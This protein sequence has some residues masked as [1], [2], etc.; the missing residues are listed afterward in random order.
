M[1]FRARSLFT[2]VFTNVACEKAPC[3][4]QQTDVHTNLLPSLRNL[5][6]FV[7]EQTAFRRLQS[8]CSGHPSGCH[9][10]FFLGWRV[11]M[12]VAL[13]VV[14]RRA[15][16]RR[17]GG[18]GGVRYGDDFVA[19]VRAGL[20]STRSCSRRLGAPLQRANY[21][22]TSRKTR[23]VLIFI[24]STSKE[25]EDR[26]CYTETS[27]LSTLHLDHG[28]LRRTTCRKQDGHPRNLAALSQ[29]QGPAGHSPRGLGG[30][31]CSHSWCACRERLS[32][33]Q[34]QRSSPLSS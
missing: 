5:S 24:S 29:A 30:C 1:V 4:Y 11:H 31:W 33:P 13:V 17:A 3:G 15:L 27:T 28:G 34:P 22:R 7:H 21:M 18:S 19:V 8:K 16:R 25:Q 23:D 32:S 9:V 14:D 20:D 10:M 26:T 6:S 2:S 12:E